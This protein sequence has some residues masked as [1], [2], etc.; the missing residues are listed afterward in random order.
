MTRYFLSIALLAGSIIAY[1]ITLVRLFS[2]AQW[3]HFAYMIISLALLGFGASGTVISLMQRWLMQRFHTAYTISGL[4]YS[5]GVV[6]C[7]GLS[8][9]VPFNPMMLV[10]Q[11]SQT[12]FLFALYL[13]LTIPFFFGAACIGMVLLQFTESVNRLY[14]F[15]LFGSGVGALGII[16]MM[17]LLPPAQNLTVISAAGFCSV[18]SANWGKG[19]GTHWR[20]IVVI[21]PLAGA[22]IGYL[23]FKPISIQISP[24]KGLSSTLNFP[25]AEILSQRHSPLG[26]LHVVRSTSIHAVP[27]L[28]LGTQQSIPS[29][30]GLFTNADGMTAITNFSGDLSKLAYLDDTTSALAY[31]LIERPRVLVLG[32]GG[33]G[34]VL[35]AL[36]H[37]AVSVDAV[38]LN[39]QVVDLVAGAHRGFAG[40]IYRA[41]SSYPVQVHIAEARGFVKSTVE[42]YDLIQIALLDSVSASAAGTHA[43][44]ESYLYTVEA[45]SDLYRRL[46]PNGMVSITRWLKT[47]PRDMIRLLAI[48]TEALE[49]IDRQLPAQQLALIRGWRTGTLLIKNGR[50]HSQ[51]LQALQRFCQE[52]SFDTA[53]Y[54]QMPELKA[55]R[56]NQLAEP[57]YF[58]AAQAI[59]SDKRTQFY[60]QYPFDIRPVTDNRPY[61]FQFLRLG[62]LVQ[63]MRTIGRNAIPFVEWGYLLLI[64]TLIQAS[65]AG[66]IL[67]LVPL[68]FLRRQLKDVR[69][70]GS[71]HLQNPSRTCGESHRTRYWRVLIY[72]L[73]LGVGFMFIEMAFIQKFLLLLADP[74]YAIAVV[75][76]AFLTFAGLG[77]LFSRKLGASVEEG[78]KLF[79]GRNP[80]PLIIGV[81]SLIAFLYLW[82]LA[83]IFDRFLAS[84]DHLKIV[85]SICLIAPLAFFMGMPFPL[86]IDLLQRHH[87]RLIAWAWGINGYASVV[88]AILAT[89]LAIAFGFNTVILLAIGVYLAGAWISGYPDGF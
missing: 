40:D 77:S 65:L 18:L 4:I 64:A 11:P 81:L 84:S 61:F 17:Y 13:I 45:I 6:G 36:Y 16:C 47:P 53:Y 15:D 68:F 32:A 59:L 35:N 30:L 73:S 44:S 49:R 22:F 39:P 74:T 62:S 54:P 89:C 19:Q 82:L 46:K 71:P 72:F 80:I 76:C 87:P 10:W 50:F 29:Q 20:R 52:R 86:G 55:N 51:E 79:R 66:L 24:Y 63:M 1:E 38:E 5:I 7:F 75:L 88:S 34:D 70:G 33:G 14:F 25:D 28:S 58:R 21:V 27:G 26:V 78:S 23:L 67:I 56:Y 31:H 60:Q 2:I 3:H 48:A 42:R 85:I 41:G 9:Y 43:L 8:Q 57:I 12:V 83:P 69:Q 37:N